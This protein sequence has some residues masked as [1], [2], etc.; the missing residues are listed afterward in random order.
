MVFY[1]LFDT[2][3][4]AMMFVMGFLFYK[5]NGKAARFLSGYTMK[6]AQARK[7]YDE[8]QMCRNYGK[9][10]MAMA[11]PFLIGAAID[12]QFAG[13]GCLVAWGLWLVQF[14]FLLIERHRTER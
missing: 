7:K 6:T 11:I 8:V 5:S 3:M 4:A 13:A 2:A 10:M 1:V 12:M 9:R 14:V